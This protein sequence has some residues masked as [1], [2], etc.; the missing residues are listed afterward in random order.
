LGLDYAVLYPTLSTIFLWA[1][2]S[3]ELDLVGCRAYNEFVADQFGEF[4][5]RLTPAALIPMYRP[6]DAL[7]ELEHAHGLGLKVPLLAA[8]VRRPI[9]AIVKAAPQ[10]A[11]QPQFSA[12]CMRLDAFGIDS[13]YDYDPVWQKC[14]DLKLPI[15]MHG[16]ALGFTD[17]ASP[18]NYVHNHMGHFAA[19]Q[20]AA[21]RSLFMGGVTRRF[22]ALKF[23]F[24]GG[25]GGGAGSPAQ[26][27]RR[28]LEEAQLER[29]AREPGSEPA[30]SRFGAQ[31]VRGVRRPQPARQG[32][33]SAG[34]AASGDGGRFARFGQLG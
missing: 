33:A 16:F 24:L 2:G 26:R 28:T 27:H 10:I 18:T 25:G 34:R 6:A 15:T 8:F 12:H 22:P 30:R 23:G 17:R 11:S 21:C 4:A 29:A 13:E 1:K 32:R 3:S 14:V 31:I 9:P 5:Q 7:A 19:A 20:E